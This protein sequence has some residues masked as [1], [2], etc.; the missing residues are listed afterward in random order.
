MRILRK[1]RIKAIDG[2]KEVLNN[3]QNRLTI[4]VVVLAAGVGIGGGLITSA[5]IKLPE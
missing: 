4:G 2:C 3:A 5:Y 1:L